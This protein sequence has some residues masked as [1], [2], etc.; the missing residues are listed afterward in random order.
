MSFGIP[1]RCSTSVSANISIPSNDNL[2]FAGSSCVVAAKKTNS[3]NFQESCQNCGPGWKH[4]TIVSHYPNCCQPILFLPIFFGFHTA[5]T[6]VGVSLLIRKLR[7]QRQFKRILGKR[8]CMF[9]VLEWCRDLCILIEDG[10][11][12]SGLVF[13][14]SNA[15]LGT[16]ILRKSILLIASPTMSLLREKDRSRFQIFWNIILL[17]VD[18]LIISNGVLLAYYTRVNDQE[19]N[20]FI[21]IYSQVLLFMSISLLVPGICLI[22]NLIWKLQTIESTLL[23]MTSASKIGSNLKKLKS[24]R[25]VMINGLIGFGCVAE[26]SFFLYISFGSVPYEF[27]LFFLNHLNFSFP[28]ML[29]FLDVQKQEESHFSSNG[30]LVAVTAVPQVNN[31]PPHLPD[32]FIISESAADIDAI[33]IL[34]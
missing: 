28:S 31:V 2:C 27:I 5:I 6:V 22:Q 21:A 18:I 17:F 13:M 10:M 11:Y 4:N 32:K 3:F 33:N 8:L 34:E 29:K 25:W 15:L 20:F 23:D 7:Q 16:E 1:F 14:I 30:P 24:F 19:Y 9:M 12:I 26:V